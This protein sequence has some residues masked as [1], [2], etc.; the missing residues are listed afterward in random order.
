MPTNMSFA[1]SQWK[2]SKSW[3]LFIDLY[4]PRDWSSIDI[5]IVHHFHMIA[6]IFLWKY[7]MVYQFTI[8]AIQWRNV[9]NLLVVQWLDLTCWVTQW[10]RMMLLTRH[11][12]I[13]DDA[14]VLNYTA[15]FTHITTLRGCLIK[16][17]SKFWL[18]QILVPDRTF[19][20]SRL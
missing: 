9:T 11:H 4:H 20:F 16:L 1:D 13:L 8:N 15:G 17:F 14:K 12:L 2:I 5:M 19:W 18:D 10:G 3:N 7:I 6:L